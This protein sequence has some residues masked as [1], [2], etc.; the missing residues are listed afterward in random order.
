MADGNLADGH[1]TSI[2]LFVLVLHRIESHW[3]YMVTN[4]TWIW[5]PSPREKIRPSWTHLVRVTRTGEDQ[6]LGGVG[7][8]TCLWYMYTSV[9]HLEEFFLKV[10]RV[11]FVK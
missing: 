9:F 2:V 10:S 7:A 3:Y 6:N 1:Y 8:R 11:V 4:G 5:F